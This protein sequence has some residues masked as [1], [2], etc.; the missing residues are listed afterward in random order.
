MDQPEL[1]QKIADLRKAKGLTQEELVERCNI[2]VRTIQ[3]IETGDVK[4][5]SYTLK[6]ILS[7]LESDINEFQTSGSISEIPKKALKIAWIAGIVYFALG[8]LE[9]PMDFTRMVQGSPIPEDV[10]DDFFPVF[11][12]SPYFYLTVKLL[13]LISY[14][15]F[16]QGF[17]ILGRYIRDAYLPI[18]SKILIAIFIL[19]IGYDVISLFVPSLDGMFVQSLLVGILGMV[20]I[21]FGVALARLRKELGLVCLFAGILEVV[22]GLLLLFLS[23]AGIFLHMLA[24]L[25]EI[26]VIYRMYTS[27]T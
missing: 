22:A 2:S 6:T 16:I 11:E 15:F 21:L 10:V 27:S 12:F 4:P 3:R 24:V 9:G 5:R 23:P 26:V 1:G 25:L 18:A 13:V 19:V 8:L 17:D 20:S 14:V 7:A